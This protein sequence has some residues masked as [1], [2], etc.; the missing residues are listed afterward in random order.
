MHPKNLHSI[1][2]LDKDYFISVVSEISASIL[3]FVS[4]PLISNLQ[5]ITRKL[6]QDM[7]NLGHNRLVRADAENIITILLVDRLTV[8]VG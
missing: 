8:D 6:E 2:T 3:N 5:I 4:I 7:G 1:S